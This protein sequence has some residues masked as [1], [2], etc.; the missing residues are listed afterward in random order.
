MAKGKRKSGKGRSGSRGKSRRTAAKQGR[1]SR[2]QLI[3]VVV[4]TGERM[5]HPASRPEKKVF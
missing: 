3:K 2:P 1:K 5:I 4:E